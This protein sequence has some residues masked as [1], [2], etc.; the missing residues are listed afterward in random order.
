M[1]SAE[2]YL[3]DGTVAANR[4]ASGLQGPD[5]RRRRFALN[6]GLYMAMLEARE[7][8]R[9]EH[10]LPVGLVS[11]R[12]TQFL[13]DDF[14]NALK[15]GHNPRS[16]GVQTMVE[17][18]AAEFLGNALI[19]YGEKGMRELTTL[20][21]MDDPEVNDRNRVTQEAFR[22]SAQG[23]FAALWPS[24]A[25]IGHVCPAGLRECATCRLWLIGD[26]EQ[27][28]AMHEELAKRAAKL[29]DQ[30]I[31]AKLRLELVGSLKVNL[32]YYTRTW[33]SIINELGDRKIGGP[34]LGKLG[35]G[36][37]HV[38]RN[39]HEVEPSEAATAASF[40]AEVAAANAK[41]TEGLAAA[42]T[43]SR[44]SNS[45]EEV[46]RLLAERQNRTDAVLDG[47]T[48]AVTALV[49]AQ[50][51]KEAVKEEETIPASGG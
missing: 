5:P 1:S 12:T 19:R 9:Q 11:F 3:N 26:P 46:L 6:P 17:H 40:G 37:H 24:F 21:M 2:Q 34:G 8:G 31:V 22:N 38:R 14:D 44:Q 29:S 30:E 13:E 33:N 25:D 41:A 32:D 45:N 49:K 20:T 23:Y 51:A 28:E 16:K 27:N 7:S 15:N 4:A 47:L 43:G 39:I 48:K 42:I 10:L 18:T 50:T 36:E 35:P